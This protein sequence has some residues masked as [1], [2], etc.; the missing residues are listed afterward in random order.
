MYA[1][2]FV[3]SLLIF[4]AVSGATLDAQRKPLDRT[5]TRASAS[6]LGN[7]KNVDPTTRNWLR[8][9]VD[10]TSIHPYGSCGGSECDF[11]GRVRTQSFASQVEGHDTAALLANFDGRGQRK[12]FTL[13]LEA[14]GRLKVQ[15]FTH[16]LDGDER[17]DYM[18]TDYFAGQ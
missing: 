17:S 10:R 9:V 7:W 15:T 6:L 5:A 11:V 4:L 1:L 12:V 8:I 3:T 14:D 2:R 18:H 13:M 16:F